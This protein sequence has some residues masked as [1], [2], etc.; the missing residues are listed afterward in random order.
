MTSRVALALL[1]GFAFCYAQSDR[2]NITG[3]VLDP[4]NAAVANAPV[5][6]V[7]TATNAATHV[8]T[9]STGEYNAADLGPGEYRVEVSREGFKKGIVRGV[10]LAAGNTLRV[11]VH[12]EVGGAFHTD[13]RGSGAKHPDTDGRCEDYHQRSEHDGG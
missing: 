9:S 12:L 5:T 3:S 11:D 6:V 7:N 10:M 4:S 1:T 2:G 8:V 13:D